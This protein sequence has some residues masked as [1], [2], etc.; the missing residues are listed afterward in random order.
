[1]G[2]NV[3]KKFH[4]YCKKFHMW[5]KCCK[6]VTDDKNVTSE[7]LRLGLGIRQGGQSKDESDANDNLHFE[8]ESKK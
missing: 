4:K 1:V 8:A 6:Q 2:K 3:S 5:Q 7:K